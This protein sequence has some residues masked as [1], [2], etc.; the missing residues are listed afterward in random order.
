MTTKVDIFGKD[1]LRTMTQLCKIAGQKSIGLMLS[2]VLISAQPERESGV[3]SLYATDLTMSYERRIP[4]DFVD[5]S[6]DEVA[7]PAGWAIV[8]NAR[9]LM[10]I[11]KLFPKVDTVRLWPKDDDTNWLCVEGLLASGKVS[12]HKIVGL[13]A[14]EFPPMPLFGEDHARQ[15]EENIKGWQLLIFAPF[16][17][18]PPDEKAEQ[19]K[20][21]ERQ[22]ELK[23]KIEQ[24]ASIIERHEANDPACQHGMTITREN[25]TLAQEEHDTP[26]GYATICE[27]ERARQAENDAVADEKLRQQIENETKEAA[28]TISYPLRDVC[29]PALSEALSGLLPSIA[30]QDARKYLNGG[31]M[32]GQDDGK[33]AFVSTDSHRMTYTFEDIG[34]PDLPAVIIPKGS[35]KFLT[36]TGMSAPFWVKDTKWRPVSRVQIGVDARRLVVTMKNTTFMSTLID[37]DFPDYNAVIPKREGYGMM[38]D[39]DEFLAALKRAVTCSDPRTHRVRLFFKDGGTELHIIGEDAGI[40]ESH[41]VVAAHIE[42]PAGDLASQIAQLRAEIDDPGMHRSEENMAEELRGCISVDYNAGFLADGATR[43]GNGHVRLSWTEMTA[44]VV[45]KQDKAAEAGVIVMPMGV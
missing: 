32:E 42:D 26:F 3:V 43:V 7:D 19:A 36:Q 6:G 16:V 24:F 4:C 15:C 10:N 25:L 39:K 21:D 29:F 35:I 14:E 41:E 1:L 17:F 12:T 28:K 11:A 31:F 22:A 9:N 34:L 13:S 20:Y 30:E 33:T 45:I 37:A 44:G 5:E 23:K 18:V 40:G 2:E 38:I 27:E 8:V